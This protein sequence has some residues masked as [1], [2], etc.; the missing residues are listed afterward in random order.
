M[1]GK[2]RV[3]IVEGLDASGKE[4]LSNTLV[5]MLEVDIN[6]SCKVIR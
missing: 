1:N 6:E 5:D 3:I 2:V 4:S